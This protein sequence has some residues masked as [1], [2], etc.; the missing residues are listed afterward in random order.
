MDAR[1]SLSNKRDIQIIITNI[2]CLMTLPDKFLGSK[3]LKTREGLFYYVVIYSIY[4]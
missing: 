3:G 1:L 2:I 4:L